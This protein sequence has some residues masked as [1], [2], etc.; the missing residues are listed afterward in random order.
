[1][2]QG[3]PWR[4]FAVSLS[5]TLIAQGIAFL[6]QPLL[7]RL[8]AP[9]AFGELSLY[10][11]IAGVLGT[12][13]PLRF[14]LALMLPRTPSRALD[15]F[16]GAMA[17]NTS[18]SL[19][20]LLTFWIG[21]TWIK[22]LLRLPEGAMEWLPWVGPAVW[23]YGLFLLFQ[24]Y[25]SRS[26]HYGK[27]NALRIMRRL[28]E[29]VAQAGAWSLGPVGLIVGEMTGRLMMI[30]T[31]FAYLLTDLKKFTFHQ[32]LRKRLWLQLAAYRQFPLHSFL[33]TLFN[34]LALLAPSLIVNYHFGSYENGL[35]DMCLQ[36]VA[37]PVGFMI[38]S[39]SNVILAE[40]S[41][42]YRHK[43][44]VFPF[45]RKTFFLLFGAALLMSL[46]V[47]GLGPRGFGFLFGPNY[48]VSATYAL[49]LLPALG[50]RLVVAPLAVTFAGINRIRYSVWWQ[51]VYALAILS[52]FLL[53]FD[54]MRTLILTY[55]W[56]EFS[57][58]SFYLWQIF[59]LAGKY[60]KSL[61]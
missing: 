18:F 3:F 41:E 11:S 15:L 43:K 39:L 54:S 10:L 46:A 53:P 50:S 4:R 13:A 31:G 55:S 61:K 42:C 30:I 14:E 22:E 57:L 51:Y 12:V 49:V 35:F 23:A 32:L 9:E 48:E 58:N 36:I 56:I 33:P 2:E 38:T 26:H 5:G 37:V 52:L 20:V 60:E 19:L 47:W 25:F 7:R 28:P 40:V 59:W 44:S 6:A 21:A 27:V 8:Y 29:C 24:Q 45:L 34:A 17:V 1:M 16:L